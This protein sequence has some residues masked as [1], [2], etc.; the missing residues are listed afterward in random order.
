MERIRKSS[1]LWNQI[2]NVKRLQTL[3]FTPKIFPRNWYDFLVSFFPFSFRFFSPLIVNVGMRISFRVSVY[4]LACCHSKYSL[5]SSFKD[6]NILYSKKSISLVTKFA[7]N[8]I[9]DLIPLWYIKQSKIEDA[10]YSCPSWMA[11][12]DPRLTTIVM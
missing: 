1:S 10:L 2:S 5:E 9:I 6:P 8:N 7:C 11:F 3:I 4:L 12:S